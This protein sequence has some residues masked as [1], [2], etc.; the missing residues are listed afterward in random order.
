MVRFVLRRAAQAVGVLALV[1]TAVFFSFRLAPGDPARLAAGLGASEEAVA[2]VRAEMGLDRPLAAQYLSYLEGLA[3][4]DLGRSTLYGRDIAG[5]IAKS[6]PATL[7]LA[8]SSLL[9]ALVLGIPAGIVSALR[10]GSMLDRL[11]ST[12]SVALLSIPNFW[13][14][15]L[16]MSGFAIRLQWLPA[17]GSGTLATLV[18]PSIAVAARLVAL[19]SRTARSALLEVL[20]QEYVRTAVAKGLRPATVVV[21]HALRN[22]SIPIVT[23]LGL[24]VGYLLGGS[25][26]VESLFSYQGVGFMLIT[27]AGAR[28]YAMVQSLTILYVA[29]FLVVNLLVDL[30]YARIDPRIQYR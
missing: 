6:L 25:V 1:L 17:G 18:L 15:L 26:V 21:K 4:L 8:A 3:R 12:L 29:T 2:R 30:A 11:A 23:L 16:L 10:P 7:A 13:L 24:Q 22:A 14:G 5:A 19:F 20:G 27:A 9:T 28:D